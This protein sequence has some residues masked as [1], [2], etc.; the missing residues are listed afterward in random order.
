M[1]RVSLVVTEMSERA[2]RSDAM[3]PADWRQHWSQLHR[4]LAPVCRPVFGDR[5][6]ARTS[7]HM[8]TA[9]AAEAMGRLD[10]SVG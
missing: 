3:R 9:A 10:R 7:S 6:A 2:H 5:S 8:T 4:A 1:N